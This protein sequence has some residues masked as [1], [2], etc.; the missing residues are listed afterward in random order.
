MIECKYLKIL[1]TTALLYKLDSVR[2]SLDEDANIM[3][4]TDFDTYNETAHQ[5][6]AEITQTFKRAFAKKIFT[7]GSPTKNVKLFMQEVDTAF[8][9]QTEDIEAVYA[10]KKTY[11]SIKEPIREAM[12]EEIR[13]YLR[14]TLGISID[15][16]D[17]K[18]L[19]RL[20]QFSTNKHLSL[21][22]KQAMQKSAMQEF[23]K[24][25]NKMLRS[26]HEYISIYDVYTFYET[27]LKTN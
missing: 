10:K 12:R 13:V 9:F 11:N 17:S 3:I 16:Y 8:T 4:V 7:R 27:N 20:L 14:S 6:N 24:L 19:V 1:D 23:I 26:K 22:T 2:E 25:I 18:E 21:Q 5:T 15:V